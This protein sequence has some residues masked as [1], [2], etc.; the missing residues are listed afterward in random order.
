MDLEQLTRAIVE[1]QPEYKHVLQ[2]LFLKI[3][4]LIKK[5]QLLKE[6][7][8]LSK[9]ATQIFIEE[10]RLLK[11]ETSRLNREIA[12][13]KQDQDFLT[14]LISLSVA[15]CYLWIVCANA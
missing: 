10:T 8:R 3:D 15:A 9:E 5:I 13:M 11:G 14:A 12:I 4:V 6:E 1:I 2:R 7:T